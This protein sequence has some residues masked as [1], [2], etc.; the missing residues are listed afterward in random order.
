MS[1]QPTLSRRSSLADFLAALPKRP[2]LPSLR[3]KKSNSSLNQTTVSHDRYRSYSV[4][5]QNMGPIILRDQDATAKLLEYILESPG[6]RRS[7]SRLARTCKAFKD[8]ALD[9]LWRDLDSLNPLLSVFPNSVLKRSRRPGL[10]FVSI[11][12]L[13]TRGSLM[14]TY[15]TPSVEQNS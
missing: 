13:H 10:G 15:F 1:S 12:R 7:L 11:L 2:R 6:G 4:Y 5:Q 9:V 3:S 14:P 8:S